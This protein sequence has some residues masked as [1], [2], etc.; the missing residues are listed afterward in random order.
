MSFALNPDQV[1]RREYLGLT[2]LSIGLVT[3][4][5]GIVSLLFLL[6]LGLS[7]IGFGSAAITGGVFVLMRIPDLVEPSEE[8]LVR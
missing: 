7:L 2:C 5:V 4:V 1:K 8:I 3:A 6:P